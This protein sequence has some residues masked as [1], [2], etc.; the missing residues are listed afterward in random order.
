MA[1]ILV[2]AVL[3]F[4]VSQAGY[5]E[6]CEQ[7]LEKADEIA[8]MRDVDASAGVERG[9]AA[10]EKLAGEPVEC[11]LSVAMMERAIA[12][13]L[14]ILG[15]LAEALDR[16]RSALALLEQIDGL[17]PEYAA[18]V[19]LT[20]GVILWEL[21]VQD[22]A[23]SHYHKALEASE[24]ANDLI[25][26]GR[27][28]GN[29]GNLYSTI[30]DL[31]RARDHHQRALEAFEQAGSV[32]GMAGSLV[33]L[34][35]LSGRQA[36]TALDASDTVE[37]SA[38]NEQMLEY[39][40][41][42]LDRF[43]DLNNPRGI[44]YAAANVAAALE[45]L[46][47]PVEALDYHEKALS[48]QREVGD[49]GG[50]TGSL[51]AMARTRY[52]IGQ[53]EQAAAL[54]D[55]A[56]VLRPGDDIGLAINIADLRVQIEQSREDY[57]AALEHQ[58]ELTRLRQMIAQNQMAARVEE[59]R[60]AM[61]TERRER[62]IELLLAEAE[63]ADLRIK[64]QRAMIAVAV[65]VTL[66]L[67]TLLGLLYIRYR[68]GVRISHWLDVAA[69]TDALTGLPNR[70]DMLERLSQAHGEAVTEGINHGLL[71]ADI[72]DFKQ[73]NDAHG[74]NVGD[75]VL[76]HVARLMQHAVKGQ[77]AIARWGGE[78]FLILLPRTDLDGAT[79]VAENIRS[80]VADHPCTTRS[81]HFN[82]SISLGLTVLNGETTVDE[83]I[84]RADRAMYS[85]KRAGK[86]RYV[87]DSGAGAE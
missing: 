74:H 52:T 72:D 50:Q 70:R 3:T 20:T 38:L 43:E 14:H 54:L 59:V 39:G 60:L 71:L 7:A 22:E 61:E 40:R 51:L 2:I 57:R 6:V 34:A 87:I 4:A 53:Y 79:A 1:R 66:L 75:E 76:V 82:L 25:G 64:R 36:R 15:D 31:Q 18:S 29:I 80:A 16:S 19:H 35:A 21:G 46:R 63:M 47:R 32:S 73:I 11:P 17:E 44:A 68:A 84:K 45:G 69:R 42:A 83:A 67:L 49:I 23:I 86:N 5:A 41:R 62:R 58:K 10:L 30:G 24:A 85:A 65:L 55:Q 12:A 26:V 28:A 37:A 8:A 77:D 9:L 27:A 81:G 48:L 13:N 33:N 78:E 56:S